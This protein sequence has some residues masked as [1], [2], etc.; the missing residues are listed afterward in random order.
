M[1]HQT[2][3]RGLP[4]AGW[5]GETNTVMCCEDMSVHVIT[6]GKTNLLF[7]EELLLWSFITLQRKP[8]SSH[9][10]TAALKMQHLKCKHLV[11][12]SN[13]IRTDPWYC[14]P[15][16]QISK[17]DVCW[18]DPHRRFPLNPKTNI[19]MHILQYIYK[20][21][22]Q[23]KYVAYMRRIKAEYKWSFTVCAKGKVV[24]ENQD[25]FMTSAADYK[26]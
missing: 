20:K 7:K 18:N 16:F 23:S 17:C 10:V 1:N 22:D 12:K 21:K 11:L 26:D 5:G 8:G 6:E 25:T 2:R 3:E 4:P 19:M 24:F 15:H 13:K 9:S 14:T